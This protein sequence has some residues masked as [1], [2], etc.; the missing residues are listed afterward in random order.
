MLRH[1]D[2]MFCHDYELRTMLRQVDGWGG[3]R[4]GLL[5]RLT[6]FYE[7]VR[8]KSSSDHGPQAL[9]RKRDGVRRSIQSRQDISKLYRQYD[10]GT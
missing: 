9:Q 5:V 1:N 8:C 10:K 7:I 2:V 3:K 4:N 6:I